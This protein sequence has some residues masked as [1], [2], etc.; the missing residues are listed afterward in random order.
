[1]KDGAPSLSASQQAYIDNMAES[2]CIEGDGDLARVCDEIEQLLIKAKVPIYQR[3]GMLVRVVAGGPERKGI[4]RDPAAPRIVPINDVALADLITRHLQ[5]WRRNRKTQELQR[6]DCP[7]AVAQTLLARQEWLFPELEAVVEHPVMLAGGQVLWESGFHAET[8][9]LLQLPFAE[10]QAPLDAPTR[11][12][13]QAAG[14]LLRE[15]LE[16]FPFMEEVDEAVAL[17]FILTPFVRPILKTAPAFSVNAFAAGSGKSTLIRTASVI[18]T[19]REPAFLA[20]SDDPAELRKVLFASLLEG[21]QHIA[22]D[23]IDVPVASS[24][25]AVILT[26]PM[27][28]GRVLGQSTNASVP[29][30][31]VFSMNGNNL[32]I[33]GDLTRRVLECRI[34]PMCD[35]PAERVFPF[36]PIDEVRS[37]RSE[38]VLAAL[39]I[40][41]AYIASGKR[42]ELRPFGSFEAW[43]RLVREPLVWLGLSDPVDSIRGLEEVDPERTQLRSMLEVVHAVYG[44]R[45]F[46][47]AELLLLAKVKHPSGQAELGEARAIDDTS[48]TALAE[49]LQAVCE[50][51]GELNARALGKW[52]LRMNGRMEAGRRFVRIRQTTVAAIWCIDVQQQG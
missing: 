41:Q 33:V 48:R 32:Q 50:R 39:T 8:G 36:N 29:T 20:Y 4:E 3:G 13:A 10:F 52:L 1:M 30:K 9:L 40:M 18:S 37:R 24:E 25:L 15:L 11:S 22:L 28:R 47:V 26:S 12:E 19:G 2:V 45:Q 42:V 44:T 38:Y 46:K 43:S 31:A 23:N 35:R 7:R 34:D 14:D 16:G 6:V 51:N 27:Y 21:D 5:V 49:A 17:A